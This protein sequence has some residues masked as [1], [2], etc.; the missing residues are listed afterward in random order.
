MLILRK[1]DFNKNSIVVNTSSNLLPH[2]KKCH[3]NFGSNFAV[4]D[5]NITFKIQAESLKVLTPT[6]SNTKEKVFRYP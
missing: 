5:R 3:I 2:L 1:W 6:F 4:F